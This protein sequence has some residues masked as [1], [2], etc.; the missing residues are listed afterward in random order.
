MFNKFILLVLLAVLFSCG[1]KNEAS[2]NAQGSLN[3]TTNKHAKAVCDCF[4]DK[5]SFSDDPEEI[6]EDLE[7]M[8]DDDAQEVGE[9]ILKIGKSIEED[10]DKLKDKKEKKLYTKNLIKSL[11]DCD[12]VDKLMDNLPYDDYGKM[13]KEA[14]RELKYL[15][16]RGD[17][18]EG[19]EGPYSPDDYSYGSQNAE[20][21]YD[22]Y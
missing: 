10:L 20:S 7:K 15:E 2:Q 16:N 17:Y 3:S 9:C 19:T 22:G 11:V 18:R 6:G 1:N 14:K 12:C 13:L 4:K 5:I 21:E 8:D